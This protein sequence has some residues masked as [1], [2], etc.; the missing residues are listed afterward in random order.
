[1][2]IRE[3]LNEK[4]M[5]KEVMDIF[6][7]PDI[8]IGA[9]FEFLIPRIETDYKDLVKKSRE[10]E[11]YTNELE[12]W[13][14]L[15][16]SDPEKW[17]NTPAPILPDWAE[18]MGY[19]D[20]E[21]I[22]F[23]D[24][25]DVYKDFPKMMKKYLTGKL[26][27]KNYIITGNHETK[28]TT[29]W[30]IKPDGS[31]GVTG[32][33]VVSPIIPLPEFLDLCPKLFKMIDELGGVVDDSCGLHISM[34]IK[35][36]NNLGDKLD[37]LKLS[38][39]TDEGYIYKYF[40]SRRFND[41]AESAHSIT[42][43][44]MTGSTEEKKKFVRKLV[45][46]NRLKKEY[47]KS[48]YDAINIEHLQTKNEYIEFRYMGGANYHKK[49]DRIKL[50]VAQHAYAMSLACDPDFKNKEYQLKLTRLANKIDFFAATIKLNEMLLNDE[51]DTPEFKNMVKV[52]KS[53]SMYL[54][55]DTGSISSVNFKVFAEIMGISYAQQG[56]FRW[57]FSGY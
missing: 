4:I 53:L 5:K 51:K 52:W 12:K 40:D 19:D 50:I 24:V 7:N 22:D 42:F 16:E 45:D 57:D 37:V 30:I 39:F 48:H 47:G 32:C 11:K 21:D 3:Y 49:W 13:E 56:N 10:Y 18:E 33:E 54:Q 20:G 44:H 31:L 27:F 1:M 46:I 9:E 43:K 55:H 2:G 38:L 36:I 8:N 35:G 15:E 14:E 28:S 26:P 34:S 6:K 41:Y 23:D 29:K 17:E 25:Y